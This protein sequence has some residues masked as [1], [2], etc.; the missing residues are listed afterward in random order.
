[1]RKENEQKLRY[2]HG[3]LEGSVPHPKIIG[4]VR[5]PAIPPVAEPMG[6]KKQYLAGCMHPQALSPII[7]YHVFY[8]IFSE[9]GVPRVI[10]MI[11]FTLVLS[12]DI[13]Y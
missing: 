3:L 6:R 5:T 11:F 4:G 7:V 8:D 10:N 2:L 12:A 1:M 13:G 9:C